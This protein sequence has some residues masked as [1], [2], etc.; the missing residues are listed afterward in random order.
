MVE[1]FVCE[2]EV[3]VVDAVLYREPVK[4]DENRSDVVRWF[5]AGDDPVFLS[6]NVFFTVQELNFLVVYKFSDIFTAASFII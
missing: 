1:S 5:G 3:F 2:E 4:V 6:E